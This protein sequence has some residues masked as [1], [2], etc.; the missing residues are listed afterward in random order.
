MTWMTRTFAPLALCLLALPQY[1]L[2]QEDIWAETE[3]V[4]LNPQDPD[5]SEVGE[6]IYK[7]GIKVDPGEENIGGISGLEWHEDALWAVSD[8]GRWLRIVP[9][10]AGSELVDLTSLDMGRLRDLKGKELKKK[11]LA[12]AEAL[13]FIKGVGW[14]IAFEQDHRIWQY[15]SIDREATPWSTSL[16]GMPPLPFRISES[17]RPNNGVETLAAHPKGLVACEE[18]YNA[19]TV[20]CARVDEFGE[21]EYLQIHP[22][23]SVAEH[24]GAPTDAA[25]DAT[26]TCFIL[27][28]SY[29]PDYGNRAAIV[30]LGADGT[31][32][33]LAVF[34]QP[35]TRDNF[36]GIAFREHNGRRY[37]YLAS[38]D[39]YNNC[40]KRARNGC[41]NTLIMKFEI[42]QDKVPL[43][44]IEA[45]PP[46]T[47]YE[48]TAVIIETSMGDITVALETERAPI[49]AANFLLY[50]DEDRFDGT[51]FY[52]AMP[53]NWGDQPNGLIQGGT[54]WDPKRVLPG[55]EHEP[56]T[57]TGLTH[58][59]GALSMAMGEPGTANGDFSIMLGDQTGLD[60]QPGAD[61]PTLKH[62]YAVFG[63][64]TSGMDVVQAIHAGETDPDK[65]EGW[66]KGQMLAE[67]VTIIDIRRAPSADE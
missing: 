18:R 50:A 45:P 3:Q 64:V 55:I 53:I 60:A 57:T 59:K 20:N 8:D 1:V 42:K 27:F 10:E 39:N 25:C 28:R 22:P 29:R 19:E 54:Q 7:G 40:F 44:P 14:L 38:D 61:D 5:A 63:Y 41:Q 58:T 52:R 32:T 21:T 49:T 67:P 66:M 43:P 16:N 23:T 56:T 13:T 9:D 47:Q 4:A 2:A 24:G 6:L 33:T 65:G 31:Q 26:G 15:S 36:E 48:T 17:L 35:L 34:D 12:D 37:L 46:V 30:E 51:V 11:E 62:G